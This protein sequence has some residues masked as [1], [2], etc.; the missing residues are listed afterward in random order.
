MNILDDD[1]ANYCLWAESLAQEENGDALACASIDKSPDQTHQK[2]QPF[3]NKRSAQALA[4]VVARSLEQ[5]RQFDARLKQPAISM[6]LSLKR[7]LCHLESKKK[8]LSYRLLGFLRRSNRELNQDI[9]CLRKAK[10]ALQRQRLL[11][12]QCSTKDQDSL[13]A[14]HRQVAEDIL[15][16]NAICKRYQMH[17]SELWLEGFAQIMFQ[18]IIKDISSWPHTSSPE[19]ILWA[20]YAQHFFHTHPHLDEFFKER[21]T[22]FKPTQAELNSLANLEITQTLFFT[23]AHLYKLLPWQ[24]F[25]E[26]LFYKLLFSAQ[27][28]LSVKTEKT[29]N[30]L[31]TQLTGPSSAVHLQAISNLSTKEQIYFILS[32]TNTLPNKTLEA[33]QS[34]LF[35][36]FKKLEKLEKTDLFYTLFHESDSELT[37]QALI[38]NLSQTKL[39]SL[40][41]FQ[42]FQDLISELTH[43]SKNFEKD[44]NDCLNSPQDPAAKKHFLRIY[45]PHI[46]IMRIWLSKQLIETLRQKLEAYLLKEPKDSFSTTILDALKPFTELSP[47][48][49]VHPE[50]LDHLVHKILPPDWHPLEPHIKQLLDDVFIYDMQPSAASESEIQLHHLLKVIKKKAPLLMTLTAES[51]LRSYSPK[52]NPFEPLDSTQ[53]AF[54]EEQAE[55]FIQNQLGYTH[56]SCPSELNSHV[57]HKALQSDEATLSFIEKYKDNPRYLLIA[58]LFSE[59][60]QELKNRYEKAVK[61]YDPILLATKELYQPSTVDLESLNRLKQKLPDH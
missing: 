46:Q 54:L 47:D 10:N 36:D 4:W 58:Q 19:Q 43:L 38:Q 23:V 3:S 44:L 5:I 33:F 42:F 53:L 41:P 32:F 27:N 7:R 56:A 45:T 61:K 14:D 18:V 24:P 8:R 48:R 26:T 25:I 57:I 20:Y 52:N 60:S 1:P 40:P 50:S 31:F 12:G 35:K 11:I 30:T 13:I 6:L 49:H 2:N 15:L 39:S 21:F 51:A 37:Q 9:L 22:Q 28:Y 29:R 17:Q 55:T 16:F 59:H 34:Q